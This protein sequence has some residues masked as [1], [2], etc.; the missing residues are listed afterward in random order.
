MIKA[1]FIF[2]TG[3]A[4]G[5]VYGSYTVQKNTPEI[6]SA[7]ERL[8]AELK[9]S[10]E[11]TEGSESPKADAEGDAVEEPAAEESE[12]APPHPDKGGDNAPATAGDPEWAP[13]D[14]EGQGETSS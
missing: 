8:I 10:S 1:A 5:T 13:E 4:V 9:N 2:G 6:V 12:T 3:F 7:L 14:N 11:K